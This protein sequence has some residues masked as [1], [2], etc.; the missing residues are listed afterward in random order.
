MTEHDWA[1]DYDDAEW[2]KFTGPQRVDKAVHMLEGII[3]GLSADRHIS[4][5]EV[6]ALQSWLDDHQDLWARE[7][8]IEL[9]TLLDAALSDG[10]LDQ[11]EQRD[12]LWF[13]DRVR[14]P[15]KYFDAVTSDLQRL[16]GMLIG[17]ASDGRVTETELR[18]LRAWLEEHTDL[19]SSW[20]YDEIDSLITCVLA[21]GKIDA[22]EQAELVRFC[23][24]FLQDAPDVAFTEAERS[25]LAIGGV[26][27]VCPEII[28][29]LR[30]FCFTGKA[31]KTRR[32]M[33]DTVR[34]LGG[35]PSDGVRHDTHY[36][37]V[38]SEG[39][40]AWAY[41]CYG[42]KIEEAVAMRREGS[43]IMIVHEFDFWDAVESAG[44][45]ER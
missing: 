1:A 42:R 24:E 2:T 13:C 12:I 38:G 27:A 43:H 44:V 35:R 23:D 34:A 9:K 4:D 40:K 37:I 5:P 31:R 30:A 10:R 36:L 17:I 19:R 26:C 29:P 8:F 15:N 21:D 11:E 41:S 7:P 22:T 14:T 33:S 16:Q 45:K 25:Q 18:Q 28:F 6:T 3:R 39:N 32:E 20:P